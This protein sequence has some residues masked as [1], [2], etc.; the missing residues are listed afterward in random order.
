MALGEDIRS[1]IGSFQPDAGEEISLKIKPVAQPTGAPSGLQLSA[2]PPGTQGSSPGAT[3]PAPTGAA[4]VV[5][6]AAAAPN[7]TNS[8]VPPNQRLTQNPQLV[9]HPLGAQTDSMYEAAVAQLAQNIRSQYAGTLR[10][11]GYLND[12]GGFVPGMLEIEA[13]RQRAELQRQQ[14][15]ARE[16]VTHGAIRGNTVFSGRRAV[17]QAQAEHPLVAAQAQIESQLAG[18]IGDR[19]RQATDLLRQFTVDRDLLIAEAAN[20]AAQRIQATPVGP[21]EEVAPPAEPAPPPEA[22][23]TPQNWALAARMLWG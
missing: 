9:T 7:I 19:Y 12:Q 3:L 21:V 8:V 2:G 13:A 14:E 16:Q 18:A 20:R 17:L 23:L 22:A 5:G 11:L 15:L 1:A 4:P 6:G 10:D